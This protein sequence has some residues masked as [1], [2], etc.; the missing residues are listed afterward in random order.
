MST[1]SDNPEDPNYAEK[2]HKPGKNFD[3]FK[4]NGPFL[5][6]VTK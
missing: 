3:L 1:R 2:G 4:P 5:K 6:D